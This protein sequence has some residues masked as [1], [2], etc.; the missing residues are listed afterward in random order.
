[1]TV[2]KLKQLLETLPDDAGVFLCLDKNTLT[3]VEG[4]AVNTVT[5]VDYKESF[6][7]Y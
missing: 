1:M 7:I 4:I 2:E 6:I 5:E 3:P